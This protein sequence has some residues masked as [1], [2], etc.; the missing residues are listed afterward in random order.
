MLILSPCSFIS[1]V[2][3][4]CRL[5]IVYGHDSLSDE[6]VWIMVNRDIETKLRSL[7]IITSP[8]SVPSTFRAGSTSRYLISPNDK[9]LLQ[10]SNNISFNSSLSPITTASSSQNIHAVKESTISQDSAQN[11]VMIPVSEGDILNVT[12]FLHR[13]ER[14]CSGF[15]TFETSDEAKKYIKKYETANRS[16]VPFPCSINNWEA[17]NRIKNIVNPRRI[18]KTA[19]KLVYDFQNRYYDSASGLQVPSWIKDRWKAIAKEREDITVEL[20]DH[21]PAFKQN[22]VV[23][24]I[25]GS[26]L[27]QKKD[28]VII[29]AHLDSITGWSRYMEKD[30]RAPGADDNAS[31]I[32]V[33]TETLEVI[34]QGGF[35]PDKT[36]KIIA[37][38]AEEV[39]LRGSK[40]IASHYRSKEYNV[41]GM[42]NFDMV[43]YTDSR[44]DIFIY[45]DDTNQGQN[46]FLETL[47]RTYMPDIKVGHSRCG[48]PCSDHHSWHVERYPASYVSDSKLEAPPP[49]YHTMNDKFVSQ[50]H[51]SKFARLAVIYLSEHAKLTPS[52]TTP[53]QKTNDVSKN[54]A[55]TK[56]LYTTMTYYESILYTLRIIINF[57]Y[58]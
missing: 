41:I 42:L 51:M 7:Q 19:N 17:T 53:I 2:L 36:I 25:Q 29:G 18:W 39:G 54:V 23:L 27:T 48:S 3:E 32:A 5:Q 37:F 14:R 6:K 44:K 56:T 58:Y 46:S 43:G 45:L 55:A 22:S 9:M 12:K 31:G 8:P 15:V 13:K 50:E 52:A 57:Q 21:K 35:K 47:L 28:I 38:A 1:V 10:V 24:T 20:Y 16:P 11:F 49:N 34:V 30:E 33:L 26:S 4:L 40:S